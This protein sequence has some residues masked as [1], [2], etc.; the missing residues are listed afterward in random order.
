MAI[1]VD[2]SPFGDVPGM[3]P[4]ESS[5]KIGAGPALVNY[6]P[7]MIPNLKLRDLFI[8]TAKERKIPLPQATLE[9]G[10]YDGGP[11][12]LHK[13]GVPTVVL[14]LPTRH[15][16]SHNAI[17]RRD[18]FDNAVKLAVAVIQRLD[19]NTVAGLAPG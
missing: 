12:H 19:K 15:V 18:D 17:L 7:H 11:I 2:V 6:D 8:D 9:F 1:I 10:G 13:E 16:H 4:E 14:G 5:N 3:K